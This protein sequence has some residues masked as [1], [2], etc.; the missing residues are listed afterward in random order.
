M[1]CKKCV[2]ISTTAALKQMIAP[3]IL[4][5]GSPLLVG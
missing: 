1:R 3:G 2:A 4:V 5:M